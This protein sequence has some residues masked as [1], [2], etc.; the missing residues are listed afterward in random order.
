MRS[1]EVVVRHRVAEMTCYFLN[2]YF[3][4]FLPL[5]AIWRLW[6]ML[7]RFAAAD[8]AAESFA[9]AIKKPGGVHAE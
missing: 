8:Q 6:V 4:F 3:T 2:S 9:V 7:Y 1:E 5:H